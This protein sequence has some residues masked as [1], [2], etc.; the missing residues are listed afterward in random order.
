[1]SNEAACA[2][3]LRI[4]LPARED[5]LALLRHVVRGFRDP[6]AIAP[7]RMDDV[8][9]AVSE[10]AANVVLHAYGERSGTMTVGA[11]IDDSRL[12]VLVRDHGRGIEPAADTPLLGHGFS[13]MAHVASSL[14]ILGRAVGTDV[15]MTFD[16]TADPHDPAIADFGAAS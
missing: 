8:V 9:L 13:L 5:S 1:M 15:L 4:T 2:P 14:E 3:E 6:Y 11:R 16:I 12:N 7:D 10:A